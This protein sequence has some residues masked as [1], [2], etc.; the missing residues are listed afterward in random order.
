V[1]KRIK[2]AKFLELFTNRAACL[3][4]METCSGA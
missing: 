3:I 1:S 4:G 2:R